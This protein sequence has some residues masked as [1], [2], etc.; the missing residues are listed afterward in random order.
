MN[1]PFNSKILNLIPIV[2]FLAIMVK[3][4]HNYTDARSEEQQFILDEANVLK[5]YAMS[6]REYYQKLFIDKTIPLNES[7]LAALPAYSSSHIAKNFSQNNM[8]NIIVRTVSDRARNPK[9]DAD[10]SE[11]KAIEFFKKNQNVNKYIDTQESEYYQYGYALRIKDVCLKCH[12][13]KEDAPSF[14]QKRYDRA[15]DYKLGE[16]RGILSIKIPK[17][18]VH[19][20]F[21]S[22]FLSTTF[23]DLLLLLAL[24]LIISYL[25]RK[26]KKINLYLEREVSKKTSA[27]KHMFEYD[28]LTNTP[29]RLKL[30]EDLK[31]I[32]AQQQVCIALVNIDNFKDINDFYGHKVGDEVLINVKNILKTLTQAQNYDLY[33]LPSDEFAILCKYEIPKEQFVQSIRQILQTIEDQKITHEN[34]IYITFSSGISFNASNLLLESDMALKISK[35]TKKNM[36]VYDDTYNI[37]E[38]INSN[39]EGIKIIKDAIENDLI[40]PFYQPIYDLHTKT[41]K[42]YESLIR[43]VTQ[44]AK[45]ILPYQFL[46]IA[47]KSKL[48]P[49]LTKIMITKAFEYFKEKEEYE[50]SINLSINDILDKKTVAFIIK[51]LENFP[52]PQ[53]VIFEILESDQIEDYEVLREFIQ[54][55]KFYGV[56][57][58]IDDFGSGY[59]NFTNILELHLDYLKIDASIVKNITS[60][61]TSRKTVQAI[62]SFASNVGLKTI[63]EYVE[64]KESLELLE[65]LGVDYIQGYYIGKPEAA[66][67]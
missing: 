19:S 46:D 49:Q 20:Y 13:K 53:R 48:Y 18:K 36:T 41:I 26:I 54:K 45:V 5:A 8:M 64:D 61:E 9:N 66:I 40:V 21:M 56:K 24:F 39:M 62:V 23:Y 31:H 28:T 38:K 6:H 63:A 59:S 50:F 57:F 2:F 32:D 11:L 15:Y 10:T 52:N 67:I 4:F 34:E 43:I 65:S 12:A 35:T 55:M 30:I 33:K 44:D 58:A 16:V 3:I 7:T 37:S 47:I 42:K 1:S 17:E 29:N 60:S 22:N 51:N 27:L 25:T 14:I